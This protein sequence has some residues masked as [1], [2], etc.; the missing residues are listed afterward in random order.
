MTRLLDLFRLI[1]GSARVVSLMLIFG[2]AIYFVYY[3]FGLKPALFLAGAIVI[4][5]LLI[6]LYNIVL[7]ASERQNGIAFGK[8]I[9]NA[10]V[11]ASAAEVKS[12]VGALG[13]KWRE[14]AVNLKNAGLDMYQL[15]W[16]MLIGEPQSGKS[17]TLKFSGI[18]FPIG[19]ESIS[20]GGGTRNCDWWFTEQSVILDT[21]GRLTFQEENATDAAE[22]IHFLNLLAKH[23]PYCPINGVLL[24]IPA[25]SLLGDDVA[26]RQMKARNISGKLLNIQRTMAIQFPVFVVITKADTIYGFTQFFNKLNVDQ[27]REMFGWSTATLESGFN[28]NSFDQSFGQMMERV[29]QIRNRNLSR[30]HYSDDANKTYIF[31]EEFGALYQPLREYMSIIFEDSVY[32]APMFFRGYYFTSGMQEG[33][34]IANA[35]KALLQKGTVI[36]NLEQV[37]SKSRA[38]FIR[39]FY[40]EKVFPEMGLV[41]R[42]FHHVRADKIKR[43]VIYGLNISFVVLGAIF[44][45]IMYRSLNA[46]LAGPKK[47]IDE[48]LTM[49]RGNDGTFFSNDSDRE[50]VYKNLKNLQEAIGAGQESSVFNLFKG[51]QNTLTAHL[52]DTF[53][54]VYLDRFLVGLYDSV[55]HQLKKFQ[56]QAP[57]TPR[58][59]EKELEILLTALAEINNWRFH[60]KNGSLDDL[61]PTLTPFLDMAIDHEWNADLA[62]YLGAN[63]LNDQ[64][65]LWFQNVHARS[66]SSVKRFVIEAMVERSEEL[67]TDLDK[68]VLAFYE[69]QPEMKRYTDKLKVLQD[70]DKAY[71]D[72]RGSYLSPTTYHESLMT[73][74]TFFSDQN[75]DMLAPGGDIYLK[76]P[77]IVEKT[78]AALGAPF[79]TLGTEADNP[80]SREKKRMDLQPETVTFMRL[81]RAYKADQF[82]DPRKEREGDTPN[83]EGLTY[84][85]E[86]RSFWDH[87]VKGYSETLAKSLEPYSD[88]PVA[89]DSRDANLKSLFRLG[90]ERMIVINH[91]A[92]NGIDDHVK[93]MTDERDSKRLETNLQ[94]YSDYLEVKERREFS[95]GLV[96]CIDESTLKV[97]PPGSRSWGSFV[98]DL[99]TKTERGRRFELFTAPAETLRDLFRD[100]D[101]ESEAIFGIGIGKSIKDY[102][103]DVEDSASKYYSAVSA[104]ARIDSSEIAQNRAQYRGNFPGRREIEDLSSVSTEELPFF[105]TH[106]VSLE[107]WVQTAIDAFESSVG[108]AD[109]CPQCSRDISEIRAKASAIGNAFP[110]SVH[111]VLKINQDEAG[112]SNAWVTLADPDDLNKLV[113]AIDRFRGGDTNRERFLKTRKI[114][115]P[116]KRAIE[117]ADMVK[118]I[119][120]GQITVRYKMEPSSDADAA[121]REFSFCDLSGYYKARRLG[122]NSPSFRDIEINPE[123]D[124]SNI[125]ATFRLFNDTEGNDSES[126]IVVHGKEYALFG[127]VL[128]DTSSNSGDTFDRHMEI[129]LNYANRSVKG[130][131]RFK[132]SEPIAI[133]PDWTEF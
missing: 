90:F 122:L 50:D 9:S 28:L 1:P 82:R 58:Q 104:L 30:T 4:I 18:K 13:Q 22:W 86:I 79:E 98:S 5:F 73:F 47:A 14:A 80:S 100:Y 20:G 32:R 74:A 49:F 75:Q 70:L 6:F 54:Y 123:A 125:S 55:N 8:A 10:Q 121:S 96:R 34:P 2:G 118:K 106:R 36:P 44:M 45:T 92:G 52:Q 53:S 127:F 19:M 129:P 21:A 29:D 71:L 103:K 84:S 37:F 89:T 97:Q 111:N 57:A 77:E 66:S 120:A 39:D 23:R 48:T 99:N 63:N 132:F 105:E 43:R 87:V 60:A 7:K 130:L 51:R 72:C 114:E 112:L 38:F 116:M 126:R 107:E 124:E 24:V 95:S 17:T 64:L 91:I 25:T 83:P 69:K 117:W 108:S 76:I 133:P 101:S 94:E 35:C 119:Q 59:S 31:P 42:A 131:F 27:Q 109:P 67:F 102:E 61:E 93:H 12:A 56:L 88:L 68:S 40:T 78:A 113:A 41:Q 46:R 16:Y 81:I 65:E 85:P 15:P 115:T 3:Q 11:G 33:Q 26:T 110:V 62:Q 128:A